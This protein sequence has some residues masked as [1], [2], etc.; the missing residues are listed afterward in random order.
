L[1]KVGCKQKCYGYLNF[2]KRMNDKEDKKIFSSYIEKH[3]PSMPIHHEP[4][5]HFNA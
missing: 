2:N 5:M 4:N 1:E 3:T